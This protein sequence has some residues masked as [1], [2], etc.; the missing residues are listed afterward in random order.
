VSLGYN[1]LQYGIDA[2]GQGGLVWGWLVCGVVF[3]LM[4][5]IPLAVALP[6]M[7]RRFMDP[8]ADSL[9]TPRSMAG[10]SPEVMRTVGGALSAVRTLRR[11][12]ALEDLARGAVSTS[13]APPPGP[14]KG[15]IVSGLERLDALHR[16]GALDDSEY[17]AAKRALLRE[18]GTR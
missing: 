2:P 13:E 17:E 15:D 4:G 6:V 11:S 8:D 10:L 5:G 18:E 12:G 7:S 1:F 3:V 16:S 14:P 9:S